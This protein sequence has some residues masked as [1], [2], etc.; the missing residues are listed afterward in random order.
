[1]G[2]DQI[3]YAVKLGGTVFFFTLLMIVFVYVFWPSNR[4]K[5]RSAASRPLEDETLIPPSTTPEGQEVNL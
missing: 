4:E 5:F 1:M 2:Y 3:A